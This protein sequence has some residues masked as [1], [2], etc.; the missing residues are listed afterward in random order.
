M[1]RKSHPK[2]RRP[3]TKDQLLPLPSHKV[4]DLSLEAH[5]ALSVLRRGHGEAMQI[6]CL[7]KTLYLAYF[8]RDVTPSGAE[9]EQFQ[10]VELIVEDCISRA[11]RGEHWELREEDHSAIERILRLYDTQLAT[12]PAYRFADAWQQLL[13][14]V[15]NNCQTPI[16][17]SR[18]QAPTIGIDA[19]EGLARESLNLP[20][21][22]RR[23]IESQ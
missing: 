20:D 21:S 7:A 16:D 15:V 13:R 17:G 11:F 6:G 10:V 2:K 12:V 9:I 23:D 3:L 14:V 1:A 5:I 8:M 18:V 22:R 19:V 4:R